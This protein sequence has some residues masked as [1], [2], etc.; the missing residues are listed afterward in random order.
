MFL[1][2]P[3]AAGMGSVL[4]LLDE[5]IG[6]PLRLFVVLR[7]A[8]VYASLWGLRRLLV[9]LAYCFVCWVLVPAVLRESGG[10][11]LVM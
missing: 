9:S 7:L 3:I 6:I 1:S 2:G 5:P 8:R 11:W 4:L 10:V